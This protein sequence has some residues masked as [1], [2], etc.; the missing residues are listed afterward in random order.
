MIIILMGPP[1]SGKG[2][3]AVRLAEKTDLPHIAVGD[4]LREAVDSKSKLGKKAAEFM[5]SGSLVPDELTIDLVK[6]RLSRLDCDK[7][8]ILDGFPRSQIQADALEEILDEMEYK[9]VYIDIPLEEVIKRNSKRVSCRSCRTVYNI[10]NNPTT[11]EGVCDQC[12]GG[13]YQ[14]DDDKPDVI[15]HRFGVYVEKTKPLVDFYSDKDKLLQV[16]GLGGMDAVFEAL[17]GVLEIAP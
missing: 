15:K 16:S 9:V 14:R 2:T 1:G 17:L 6:E 10:D 12:G 11:K 13:L 3:Q 4:M 5:S 7:G 8:F